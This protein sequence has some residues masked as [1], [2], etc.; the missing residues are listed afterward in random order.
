ML[1]LIRTIYWNY[2]NVAVLLIGHRP[3]IWQICNLT[4]YS[5]IGVIQELYQRK[6]REIISYY[7]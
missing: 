6:I 3:Y 4:L 2:G 1:L 5:R 7:L